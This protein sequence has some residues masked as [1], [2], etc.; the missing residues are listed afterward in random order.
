MDRSASPRRIVAS[1]V[2]AVI[3]LTVLAAAPVA[4][5]TGPYLVKDIDTSG[6]SSPS[7][8]VDL[9]GVLVFSAKGGG[10]GRELWRSDGTSNGTRRVKDIR[11]GSA[12][13]HPWNLAAVGGAV[14]FSAN[15]GVRG[16]ELWVSNGTSAGTRL[17]KDINPGGGDSTPFAF[18]EFN[19]NVYFSADD[20]ATGRELWRTDGTTAGTR[21]IKDIAPGSAS[22][23]PNSF[24]EIAGK[25]IFNRESC[26]NF[27]CT[28]TLFTTDGTTGGTKPFRDKAGN[29]IT[30][31]IDWLTAVGSRLFF[32]LDEVEL[33]RSS[34]TQATTKRIAQLDAWEIVG[35]G[36]RAFFR[37]GEEL[38]KSDGTATTTNFVADFENSG[39]HAPYELDGQLFF[40]AHGEP[41]TSDGTAA[42]TQ[43]VGK[44]VQADTDY[45]GLGSVVY[46]GG[47]EWEP[48]TARAA[49]SSPSFVPAPTLTLWRS[50]GTQS[51]TYSVG[52]PDAH[53]YSPTAVGSSVF[54]VADAEGHG[55]ELWRYVP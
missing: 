16:R 26:V 49:S 34:G 44:Q 42:G 38:W 50:D 7:D 33:W 29:K 4:A 53:M 35:V 36:S 28:E 48:D 25:L 23:N 1:F 17:L 18:A 43:P 3:A 24:V 27:V 41:W 14:Y 40:F 21:R 10:K 5:G 51:G 31:Q 11:P 54:F 2:M 12:G 55:T 52:P 39:V 8:L 30:G 22:S 6:S 9:N 47:W 45:A 20:G 19:G 13:S 32:V 15:D 46:F 37:S